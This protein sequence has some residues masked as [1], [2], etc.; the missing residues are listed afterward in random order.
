MC[1]EKTGYGIFIYYTN[2][3]ESFMSFLGAEW[4]EKQVPK[5]EKYEKYQLDE[6]PIE[7][8][9]CG[10]NRKK[11]INFYK[12]ISSRHFIVKT[13]RIIVFRK[14]RIF[15]QA[16]VETGNWMVNPLYYK[17]VLEY[18]LIQTMTDDF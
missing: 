13:T 12:S 7:L 17:V 11:I 10:K 9:I 14:R 5:T 16:G 1:L 15:G 2:L 4:V 6:N 8:V 18:D 3:T